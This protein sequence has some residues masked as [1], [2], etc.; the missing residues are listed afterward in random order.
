MSEFCQ[1]LYAIEN[2]IY[3]E[4]KEKPPVMSRGLP[5]CLFLIG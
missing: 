2:E 4:Q 5:Q 1:N 3:S